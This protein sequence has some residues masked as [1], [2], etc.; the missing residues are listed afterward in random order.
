[1]PDLDS[2]RLD[3]YR[4]DGGGGS[5]NAQPSDVLAGMTF[6][7]DDGEQIGT[8][9]PSNKIATG[10][11][12]SGLSGTIANLSFK[13]QVV[14][15]DLSYRETETSSPSQVT[16]IIRGYS[17]AVAPSPSNSQVVSKL[18]SEMYF[19]SFSFSASYG[20]GN[21]VFGSNY[22]TWELSRTGNIG[23]LTNYGYIILGV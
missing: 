11:I 6:T 1:M 2:F 18:T 7:N 13:P 5:G 19:N 12:P 10:S 20:L 8:Y 16:T 4:I 23:V 17:V 14:L 22:I 21:V 3:Q 15:F 9:V